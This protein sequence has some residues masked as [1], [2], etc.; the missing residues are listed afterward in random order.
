LEKSITDVRS[1]DLNSSYE[2][3][4]FYY[5]F[6]AQRYD[7]LEWSDEFKDNNIYYI[8]KRP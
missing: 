3:T 4:G 6:S 1:L 5:Y 8:P 7:G 2:D